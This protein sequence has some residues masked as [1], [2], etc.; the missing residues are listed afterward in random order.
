VSKRHE[1][2]APDRKQPPRSPGDGSIGLVRVP[3]GL[4]ITCT[5]DGVE[6]ELYASWFNAWRIFGCLAMFFD[7]IL[8][9]RVSKSITINTEGEG[10]SMTFG[11]PENAT[12]GEK[13]AFNLM[14][15]GR[16]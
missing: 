15:K 12:L 1:D 14:M 11:P 6:H 2:E 13:L 4:R 5:Q 9:K 7:V 16:K 3:G 8:P 10:G